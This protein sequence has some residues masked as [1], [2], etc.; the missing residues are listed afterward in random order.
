MLVPLVDATT[1]PDVRIPTP[2]GVFFEITF[3]ILIYKRLKKKNKIM[4][5]K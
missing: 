1:V 2:V 3:H 4:E 5:K